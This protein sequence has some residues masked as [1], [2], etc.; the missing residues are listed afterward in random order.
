MG[1][2]NEQKFHWTTVRPALVFE[3]E[4]WAVKRSQEQNIN[5]IE[6]C[7][8]WYTSKVSRR[9]FIKNE[10]IEESL[11]AMNILGTI[12]EHCLPWFGH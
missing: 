11:A 4:W 8:L 7:M 10:Y 6:M 3:N 1:V 5:A 12:T 9:E 2:L